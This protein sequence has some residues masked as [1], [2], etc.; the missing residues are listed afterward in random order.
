[1]QKI[2]TVNPLGVVI[3]GPRMPHRRYDAG[4]LA[5]AY[6]LAPWFNRK[7]EGNGHERSFYGYPA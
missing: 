4:W 2:N 5:T 3:S 7:V 6:R 1:M